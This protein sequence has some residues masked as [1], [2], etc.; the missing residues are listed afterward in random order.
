MDPKAQKIIRS[1]ME[2][3]LMHHGMAKKYFLKHF[4]FLQ[5]YQLELYKYR[6][7]IKNRVRKIHFKNSIFLGKLFTPIYIFL[8]IIITAPLKLLNINQFNRKGKN[9]MLINSKSLL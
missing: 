6:E 1:I 8:S 2:D 9:L 3:E 7:F 4:P 5:P